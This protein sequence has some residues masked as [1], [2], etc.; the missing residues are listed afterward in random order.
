[1]KTIDEV[2]ENYY[3]TAKEYMK[4]GL[5]ITDAIYLCT[6]NLHISYYIDKFCA[7]EVYYRLK[8][9]AQAQENKSSN[10]EC[11]NKATCSCKNDKNK[12]VEKKKEETD[13]SDKYGIEDAATFTNIINTLEELIKKYNIADKI[14]IDVKSDTDNH[15]EF[16]I[17]FPNGF[18][19]YGFKNFS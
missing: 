8:L 12:N 18:Y 14:N 5:S 2:I 11:C 4:M 13:K 1:M 10:K 15:K 9:E 3:K 6:K 19:S 7:E 16:T 17:K